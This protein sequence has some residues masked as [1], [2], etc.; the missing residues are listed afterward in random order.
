MPLVVTAPL[1]YPSYSSYK[2]QIMASPLMILALQAKP[3]FGFPSPCPIVAARCSLTLWKSTAFP[4]S[5]CASLSCPSLSAAHLH[6]LIRQNVLSPE[7]CSW[8]IPLPSK[9]IY[10]LSYAPSHIQR[11]PIL[12]FGGEQELIMSTEQWYPFVSL[13]MFKLQQPRLSQQSDLEP[14]LEPERQEKWK[15]CE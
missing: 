13:L 10:S 7:S 5:R 9:K 3:A 14:E 8:Q 6:C 2:I 15:G 1:L 4:V 11:T 12:K